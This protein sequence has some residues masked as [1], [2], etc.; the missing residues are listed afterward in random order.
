MKEREKSS[1]VISRSCQRRQL[2]GSRKKRK[3][4]RT[5]EWY[6]QVAESDRSDKP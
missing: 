4:H 2:P 1:K 3:T 5:E 6:R